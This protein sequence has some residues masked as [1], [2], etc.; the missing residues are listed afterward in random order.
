LPDVRP[1][2]LVSRLYTRPG[3]PRRSGRRCFRLRLA[4]DAAEPRL[5]E[6]IAQRLLALTLGMLFNALLGRAPRNLVPY[7]GR[8]STSSL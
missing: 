5:V 6:R 2:A 7:D 8:N 1:I 3:S 4:E